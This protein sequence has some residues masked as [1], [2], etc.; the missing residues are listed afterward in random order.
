MVE[1]NSMPSDPV[2]QVRRLARVY[3]AVQRAQYVQTEHRK[4]KSA[5]QSHAH[6]SDA[7]MDSA[8]LVRRVRDHSVRP[9]DI[10]DIGRAAIKVGPRL[11]SIVARHIREKKH[12]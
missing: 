1:S 12:A 2:E 9:E 10:R 5:F 8:D 3:R 7:L 11:Y 4:M 6:Q